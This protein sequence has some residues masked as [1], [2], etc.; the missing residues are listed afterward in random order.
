[1]SAPTQQPHNTPSA[2]TQRL[3]LNVYRQK[4]KEMDA[5]WRDSVEEP[6]IMIWYRALDFMPDAL[7]ASACDT[8]MMQGEGERVPSPRR[9]QE[10]A[11]DILGIPK[12]EEAWGR[13]LKSIMG[14]AQGQPYPEQDGPT[15]AGVDACGG[16]AA[17]GRADYTQ[18]PFLKR[19]FARAY[20]ALRLTLLRPYLDELP[21]LVG[22]GA[23]CALSL[24]DGSGRVGGE[25]VDVGGAV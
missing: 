8:L 1:M 21:R 17:I 5:F 11:C 20:D 10:V 15:K 22:G 12:G 23:V 24:S 19:E 3:T 25:R 13:Y 16:N 4:L 6:T 7:F 2:V 9:I 14:H 18:H